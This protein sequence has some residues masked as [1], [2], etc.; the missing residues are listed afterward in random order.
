MLPSSPVGHVRAR[1]GADDMAGGGSAGGVANGSKRRSFEAGHRPKFLIVVDDT[2]ECSRAVRFGAR[3]CARTGASLVMLG[4]V[5]QPD[6]FEFL[7]VGE[8]LRADAEADADAVLDAAAVAVRRAAGVEPERVVKSGDK[9]DAI[10]ELIGE[11]PD[12]S[13]LVLG[14]GTG[15]GGPGPLVSSMA[16]RTAATFPIPVVIVPGDLDD[17]AIDALAG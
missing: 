6:N 1:G 2:P 9:S 5:S 3:R 13:F 16:G 8:A 17:E 4:V 10:L 12:I 15:S 7:G 14:A 11:D